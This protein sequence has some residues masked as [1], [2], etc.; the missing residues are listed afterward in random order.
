M[1]LPC[2]LLFTVSPFMRAVSSTSKTQPPST[3]SHHLHCDPLVAATRISDLD[4]YTRPL[5]GVPASSLVP[6]QFISC[7]AA[8][9]VFLMYIPRHSP[10]L[11]GYNPASSPWPTRPC[12]IDLACFF[13]LVSSTHDLPHCSAL[14]LAAC[15]SSSITGTFVLAVPLILLLPFRFQP[16]Y[17]LLQ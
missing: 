10:L 12:R 14:S 16:K 15:C 11:L 6:L 5:S 4:Y 3:A 8:K 9:A 13:G 2:P 1:I 7:I 17:H